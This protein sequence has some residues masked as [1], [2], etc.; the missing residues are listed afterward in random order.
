MGHAV[1]APFGVPI[2]QLD[3]ESFMTECAAARS[4][5][6]LVRQTTSEIDSWQTYQQQ[7]Q[8]QLYQ[9]DPYYE[10]SHYSCDQDAIY[11][12]CDS[13]GQNT[14]YQNCSDN[15]NQN[16]YSPV[17]DHDYEA[18]SETR[19]YLNLDDPGHQEISYIGPANNYQR[20]STSLT[21][22]SLST[23]PLESVIPSDDQADN[24]RSTQDSA[25]EAQPLPQTQPQTQEA[26]GNEIA[27]YQSQQAAT[28]SQPN[29]FVDFDD[30]DSDIGSPSSTNRAVS[31][32]NPR[33][34]YDRQGRVG[35]IQY[36]NNT[37]SL[38]NAD[39][40]E[41]DRAHI[42]ALKH[43]VRFYQKKLALKNHRYRNLKSLTR[44]CWKKTKLLESLET[45]RADFDPCVFELFKRQVKGPA[46]K[47]GNRWP[48]EVKFFSS[49]IYL[50]SKSAY[51]FVRKTID[52]PSESIVKR[53]IGEKKLSRSIP[54]SLDDESDVE[55]E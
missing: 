6:S 49:G 10:G 7:D 36:A 43:K 4:T 14:N 41:R 34:I 33:I 38:A 3:A 29:G 32:E 30:D 31:S 16:S 15:V 12:N 1:P 27:I 53:Y 52:L 46:T 48:N 24:N 40:K 55:S 23:P 18:T 35:R 37:L 25:R 45:C 5:N 11:S 13:T 26:Q 19:T 28:Q 21:R 2:D 39:D 47:Q 42:E 17:I 51:K 20:C 54:N 8:Q 22:P 44:T 9:E 50:C